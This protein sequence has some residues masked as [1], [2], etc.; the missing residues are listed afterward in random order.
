MRLQVQ[1]LRAVEPCLGL[2]QLY[3][4]GTNCRP[5]WGA[6]FNLNDTLHHM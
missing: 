5:N 3:V 2:E 6:C 4:L 1:A